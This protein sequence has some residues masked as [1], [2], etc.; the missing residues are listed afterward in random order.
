MFKAPHKGEQLQKHKTVLIIKP[1]RPEHY[2]DETTK[3]HAK[4]HL[5]F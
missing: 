4:R 3:R 1:N 2:R 5:I